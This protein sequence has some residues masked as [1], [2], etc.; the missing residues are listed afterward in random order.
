MEAIM[1]L[2]CGVLVSL[3]IAATVA[4][5]QPPPGGPPGFGKGGQNAGEMNLFQNPQVRAAL[6]VSDEQLA[7]LPAASLKALADVLD[8]KQ[9]QRLREI[10]WQQKGDAALLEPEVKAQLKMSQEQADAIQ[11][12]LRAHAAKQAELFEAGGFDPE[13]MQELQKATTATIRGALT[14]EQK[15]AWTKLLGTPFQKFGGFG[16]KKAVVRRLPWPAGKKA[17]DLPKAD[18]D[19]FITLFNG[20][21]L[22]NWEGLDGYWSVK[23]GVIDGSETAANSKQ[24]FLVLSASWENPAKFADFE[25]H[26]RYKFAS[27]GGNSGLQFRSWVFDDKLYGVG[28]YQADFDAATQF[29]GGIFDEA[30]VAGNR[31]IMANRGDRTTW[32]AKN[33]RTSE[34]LGASKADLGKLLKRGDWNAMVL[35]AKGNYVS[36]NINGRLM[37]ELIDESPKAL[38]DGVIAIQMHAGYTMSIQV[39]DVKI[40]LLSQ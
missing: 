23:D 27:P 18:A 9:L 2:F 21:D 32:D 22:T 11:A 14:A 30:G 35:T 17:P 40:K 26:L 6:K 28:G 5:G 19:G 38:R 33:K 39:K 3:A 10:A 13:K 1:R 16:G 34:P 36:I 20:K 15:T 29:D 7:K 31:G 25:L 24:T 12:A 37:G 4:I 8:A